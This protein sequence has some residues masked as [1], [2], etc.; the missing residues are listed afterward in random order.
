MTNTTKLWLAGLVGF[1]CV[2]VTIVALSVQPSERKEP[3]PEDLVSRFSVER[4]FMHETGS[5]TFL[6]P[7]ASG[8][9][10]QLAVSV[11]TGAGLKNVSLVKDALPGQ[12]MTVE[13][14]CGSLRPE[15]CKPI[16]QGFSV[17]RVRAYQLTV[18]LHSVDEISGAGWS[19]GKL[20]RGQTVV[21]E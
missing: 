12:P 1:L 6:I 13:F 15:R 18:H 7:Q 19:R 16:P 8:K 11:S 9:V 20:G 17:W 2:V 10:G 3:V 4:V 14:V 5:F 21:V